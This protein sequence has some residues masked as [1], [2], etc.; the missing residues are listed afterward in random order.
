[1]KQALRAVL[2][3][4]MVVALVGCGSALTRAPQAVSAPAN[5]DRVLDKFKAP[6]GQSDIYLFCRNGDYYVFMDGYKQ[7]SI[8]QFHNDERC[9]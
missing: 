7:G 5:P 8:N 3:I 9:K 2:S 1:M 6:D 4:A